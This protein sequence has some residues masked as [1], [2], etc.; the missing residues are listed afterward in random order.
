MRKKNKKD[1]IEVAISNP[2]HDTFKR[3]IHVEFDKDNGTLKVLPTTARAL[4]SPPPPPYGAL[5]PLSA[6][7]CFRV[8]PVPGKRHPIRFYTPSSSPPNRIGSKVPEAMR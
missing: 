4:S 6:R 2:K 7:A 3:G 1:G 5:P 8:S